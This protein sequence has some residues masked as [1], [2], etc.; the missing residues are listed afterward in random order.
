MQS[1]GEYRVGLTFNPS[2]N[3]TVDDIK[4]R[5]ASLIDLI[6]TIPSDREST[7]GN[8]KGR[9]KSLAKTAVEEAAMWAVKAATKPEII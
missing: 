2:N 3:S 1:I 6:D 9:L 7:L 5:A 4:T 8:E